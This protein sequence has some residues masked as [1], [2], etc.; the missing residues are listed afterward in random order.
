MGDD[1]D[2]KATSACDGLVTGD[3][4]EGDRNDAVLM[5]K[6]GDLLGDLETKDVNDDE[7]ATRRWTPLTTGDAILNYM[8]LY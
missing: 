4:D 6:D 8:N 7:R 1:D 3:A 2:L 5:S